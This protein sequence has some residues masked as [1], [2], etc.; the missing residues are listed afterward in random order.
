M[1]PISSHIFY[2]VTSGV[3][4]AKLEYRTPTSMALV[5]MDTWQNSRSIIISV[6]QRESSFRPSVARIESN[7]VVGVCRT[8]SGVQSTRRFL[9]AAHNRGIITLL[10]HS[11]YMVGKFTINA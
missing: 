6:T 1:T 2:H 11:G 9:V 3:E 8:N 7:G 10:I 4:I 5:K